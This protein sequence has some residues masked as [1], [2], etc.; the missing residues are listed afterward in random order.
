[1]QRMDPAAE[2]AHTGERIAKVIARAGRASRRD[3]ERLIA[4]GRVA[5][6]GEI[7]ASPARN[8]T[9][10]DLVTIDGT[11]LAAPSKTRLFRFYKPDR[12]ITSARDPEGRATI[13]DVLPKDLP[14]LMP[15][16][17]LDWNS[18][19]LLLLTNDGEVKRHLELPSTLWIRRYRVRAYGMPPDASA[20]ERLR[21][22]IEV[23]GIRYDRID[24][25]VDRRQGDN[26]WLTMS[27]REGKNREVRRVLAQL[28]LQ[29][30]RLIRVAY[31]AFVLGDLK[32]GDVEEVT[33]KVLREQLGASVR[34]RKK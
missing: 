29:V 11:P 24:T 3:A 20:I 9:P 7:L 2:D 22:G 18:E 15:I 12:V 34:M 8:V 21:Q 30:N 31:G 28:G 26:V 4:E 14:R 23:D 27:L 1:M 19:G 16:G 25:V 17:R 6:N 33:G 13:Y 5:V 32:P 10:E